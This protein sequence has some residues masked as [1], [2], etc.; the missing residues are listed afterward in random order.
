MKH[1]K[2]TLLI[3][4]IVAMFGVL[5][6]GCSS[7]TKET[8][9]SE[10]NTKATTQTY[11]D[12]SKHSVEI[13]TSPKR[14]IFHG[15][16]IGDLVALDFDKNVIGSYK[17]WID[18]FAYQDKFKNVQDLGLPINLEKALELNPDFIVFSGE[19]EKDYE[20]L[21][22]IA[23]TIAFETFGTL[24][25]RITELGKIFNK[26]EEAT[27]WLNNYKDNSKKMWTNLIESKTITSG[28]TASVFTCYGNKLYL[29]PYTGIADIL[30][31]ENGFKPGDSIQKLLDK[32]ETPYVEVSLETL[33]QYAGDRIF[34]LTPPSDIAEDT[35]AMKK[36]TE[37]QIWKNLKAV[38]QGYVYS[39]DRN[40]N[41]TDAYT[42]QWF[43][44]EIPKILKK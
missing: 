28:E 38:K 37:N 35:A 7:E 1:I 14:I 10:E 43:L 16:S 24:E 21:S 29:T 27:K 8:S 26:Q 34:I 9:S 18:N 12:A 25:N 13:P 44:E 33:E 22:K 23:P 4:S 36:F 42:S 11:V 6:S 2:K 19:E 39:V 31:S 30:Y 41:N 3:L 17:S 15:E 32:R 20:A 40:K 5:F